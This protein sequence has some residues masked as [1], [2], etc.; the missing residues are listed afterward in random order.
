MRCERYEECEGCEGCENYKDKIF[1]YSSRFPHSTL[2]E[3]L[4]ILYLEAD[5]RVYTLPHSH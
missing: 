3:A 2:R 1:L 4:R 5:E